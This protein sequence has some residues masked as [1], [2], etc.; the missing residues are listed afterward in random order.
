MY[1][2]RW[3][4]QKLP[5]TWTRLLVARANLVIFSLAVR[6]TILRRGV[7]TSSRPFLQSTS[8]SGCTSTP[9]I[10]DGPPSINYVKEKKNAFN[11]WPLGNSRTLMSPTVPHRTCTR[12]YAWWGQTS[13]IHHQASPLERKLQILLRTNSQSSRDEKNTLVKMTG[14]CQRFENISRLV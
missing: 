11:W 7:G 14:R 9:T 5:L 12:S 2:T 4:I 3:R 6:P 8:T 1:Q 13:N 10:P